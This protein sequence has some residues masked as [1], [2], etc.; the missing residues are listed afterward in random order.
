[1][2]VYPDDGNEGNVLPLSGTEPRLPSLWPSRFTDWIALA[3]VILK[4]KTEKSVL[5]TDARS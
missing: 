4:M 2:A 1:M 3:H 5:Y